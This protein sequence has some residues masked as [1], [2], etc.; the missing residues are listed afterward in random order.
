MS[1]LRHAAPRHAA[2]LSDFF[3]SCQHF[4]M[5]NYV[6]TVCLVVTGVDMHSAA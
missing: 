2:R 6:V 3:L 4:A 1:T 5:G